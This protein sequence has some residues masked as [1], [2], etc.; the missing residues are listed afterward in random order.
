M[1]RL[2]WIIGGLVVVVA[3][4]VAAPFIYKAARG[5]DDAPAAAVSTEGAEA[6]AGELDGRWVVVPGA[7]PN[8]TAAGYTVK[9][10]LRGEPVTVVGTTNKVTG[11]AVISDTSLESADFQVEVAGVGTDIRQRDDQAHSPSILD[12]AAYPLATLALA[13]PVDMADLPADGTPA[14]VPMQ[15]DLTV[16]G[17]TVSKTVEVTVLRSGEQVIAS[18]SVPMTW[19]EVGVEPPSLGFVTVEP[20][21]TIDFL[22]SLARA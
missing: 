8:L 11:E 2:L 14:T 20:T 15:V 5:G 4:V 18:G 1:R 19:A 13:R 12:A 10:V 6:A 22:V 9:E 16:K 21:G 3:L 7:E 17:T